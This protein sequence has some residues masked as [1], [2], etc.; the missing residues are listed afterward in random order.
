MLNVNRVILAGNLTKDPERRDTKGG[1]AMTRFR[2]AVSKKWRSRDGELKTE[3]GFFPVV[4]WNQTAENCHKYL[5]KGSPVLVEG[6]LRAETFVGSD[7]LK[8]FYTEVIGDAVSFLGGKRDQSYAPPEAG[9]TPEETT[10]T[11]EGGAGDAAG[12]TAADIPF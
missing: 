10:P 9:E 6:R 12:G 4:V 8:R 7:G 1:A 2:L 5:T 3:T 11:G